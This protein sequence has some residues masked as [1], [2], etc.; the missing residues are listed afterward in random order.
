MGMGL[1]VI[2]PNSGGAKEVADSAGITF[3]PGDYQD[4]AEKILE[5]LTNPEMYYTYSKKSIERSKFFS[6]EKAAKEYLEIYKKVRG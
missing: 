5:I 4:L 2:V 6:W 1:P 3:E